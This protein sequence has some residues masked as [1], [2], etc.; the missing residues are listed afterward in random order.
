MSTSAPRRCPQCQTEYAGTTSFC[1][2][3]GTIIIEVRPAGEEDPRLGTKLGDYVLVAHVEDGGM[4]AVYEGR[5]F[6]TKQRVA[7]K[8]LHNHIATDNV[9]VERFK[10]EYETAGDFDHPHIVTVI[11]FGETED[12]SFFLTMEFLEGEE[13]GKLLGKDGALTPARTLRILGQVAGALDTAHSYGVIHR[14][15]KPD[16]IFLCPTPEGDDA[17]VLD[18]GSVKLQMEMGPKLTA[19][20]TTL[21]S[22]YYMSP[23]QAMGKQDLDQRADVFAIAALAYELLTGNIAFSGDALADILMKIMHKEPPPASQVKTHLPASVDDAISLGLAKDKMA[24]YGTVT[25]FTE[26]L[27]RGFGL[28][29]PA[30]TLA[31]M[32]LSEI[33][34]ALRGATPPVPAP[35][36][37]AETVPMGSPPPGAHVDTAPVAGNATSSLPPL[38]PVAVNRPSSSKMPLFIGLGLLALGVVVL[39]GVGLMFA[40][41]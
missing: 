29:L 12:G 13:L 21:G 31:A 5:H 16:N 17:R 36:G 33:E 30:A 32:P 40:V 38:A 19:F 15:L 37:A 6:D 34:N 18:F 20:G 35:F 1:G 39:V 3:D 27:A 14:D 25:E 22:P 2:Q 23:E 41:R 26:G 4:G 7:V 8:V 28:E 24:R 9:A 10:R 11:D